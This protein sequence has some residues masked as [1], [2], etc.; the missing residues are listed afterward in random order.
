MDNQ[1]RLDPAANP[2]TAGD[3]PNEIDLW[4]ADEIEYDDLSEQGKRKVD[5]IVGISSERE[6]KENG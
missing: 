4:F 5:Q 6:A 3:L 1:N 2:E